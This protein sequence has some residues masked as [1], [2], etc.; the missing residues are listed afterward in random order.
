M[1]YF[2]SYGN[3]DIVKVNLGWGGEGQVNIQVQLR[4]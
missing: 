3:K 1:Y 2:Y 4:Y